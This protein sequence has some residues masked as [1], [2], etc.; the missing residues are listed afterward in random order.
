MDK[1]KQ[2]NEKCFDIAITVLFKEI[3]IYI[4][5]VLREYVW[6]FIERNGRRER[7]LCE[8]FS[9]RINSCL[10]NSRETRRRKRLERPS[11]NQVVDIRNG[12]YPHLFENGGTEI[13]QIS[14]ADLYNL[15]TRSMLLLVN[16]KWPNF[17][18]LR[19]YEFR[20]YESLR[21]FP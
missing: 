14:F 15:D 20:R 3:Y 2:A 21:A 17:E 7:L 10:G 4:Y 19:P 9:D 12:A 13:L 1:R 16:E 18:I 8:I 11:V 6:I 5:S